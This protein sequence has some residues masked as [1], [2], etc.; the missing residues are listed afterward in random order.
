M[1]D[2]LIWK[3]HESEDIAQILSDIENHVDNRY[4][5]TDTGFESAKR[6]KTKLLVNNETCNQCTICT[7]V[8]PTLN[9][10]IDI[11]D[12]EL[13]FFDVCESLEKS[14]EATGNYKIYYFLFFQFK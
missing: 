11:D 3:S 14:S 1:Q 10:Y 8:C 2:I 5:T 9:I 12:N 4:V 7:L 6:F 13:K